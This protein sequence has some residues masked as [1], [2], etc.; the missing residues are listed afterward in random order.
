MIDGSQLYH[1]TLD[2]VVVTFGYF[3]PERDL[4]SFQQHDRPFCVNNVPISKFGSG[5]AHGNRQ[6]FKYHSVAKREPIDLFLSTFGLDVGVRST[7]ESRSGQRCGKTKFYCRFVLRYRTD[8]ASFLES[9]RRR[10]L[11]LTRKNVRNCTSYFP[12]LLQRLP[13]FLCHLSGCMEHSWRNRASS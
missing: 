13:L 8:R 6:T 10:K 1:R 5:S 2:W 12:V 11:L 4:I 7:H 3:F 9:I